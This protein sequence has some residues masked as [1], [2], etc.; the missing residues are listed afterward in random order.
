MPENEVASFSTRANVAESE[1]I[2]QQYAT[3]SDTSNEQRTNPACRALCSSKLAYDIPLVI[4]DYCIFVWQIIL[5]KPK[6]TVGWHMRGLFPG[7]CPDD[8]QMMVSKVTAS[9]PYSGNSFWNCLIAHIPPMEAYTDTD[10][11][12]ASAKPIYAG[13]ATSRQSSSTPN[14]IT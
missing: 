12:L 4:Y 14:S 2:S 6:K 3:Y 10:F 7:M 9:K 5:P 1:A 11:I 13:T 8:E